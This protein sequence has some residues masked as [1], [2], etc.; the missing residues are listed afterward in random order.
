MRRLPVYI[1]IDTSGS[2]RG[3]PIESV[4]VGL[5]AMVSTLRYNP[6]ALETVWLS[7]ITYDSKVKQLLPL[8]ALANVQIP[9]ITVPESGPTHTGL[10]LKHLCESVDREVRHNTYEQKGDWRPLVFLMTDGKPSDIQLY[11][12]M[13]PE[14][15]R[16]HF[17]TMAAFAAGMNAKTEPLRK[18]TDNT[19]R[20]DTA[21][22]ASIE[23][24]FKWVSD[25]VT[26]KSEQAG[27]DGSS[28]TYPQPK[29]ATTRQEDKPAP[30][31]DTLP[32]PPAE[33]TVL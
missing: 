5:E 25:T 17:G 16:R 11:D 8:T 2:M 29:P 26:T 22:G 32:P 31:D 20:L 14:V 28:L 33:V 27:R 23:Q 3:E 24:L 9:E 18:L 19:F 13:I 1:L 30:A 12:E 21:D 7:I 10:A 15:K 4:K 6:Y